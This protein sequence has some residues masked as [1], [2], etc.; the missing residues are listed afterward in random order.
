M[1]LLVPRRMSWLL[2][3]VML[4]VVLATSK[5]PR[6][7]RAPKEVAPDLE[8]AEKLTPEIAAA[9]LARAAD[10]ASAAVR[11]VAQERGAPSFTHAY[12]GRLSPYTALRLLSAHTR[13]H[14]RALAV[15][16]PR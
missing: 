13:H 9:R 3:T 10:A 11:R 15:N 7:V 2:R 16:L 5:F 4:P 1:R 14:S 6:G 12:F 8:E